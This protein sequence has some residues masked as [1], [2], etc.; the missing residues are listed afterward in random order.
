MTGLG[1]PPERTWDQRLVRVLGPETGV[2]P[3]PFPRGE[4][5]ENITFRRT[6]YAVVKWIKRASVILGPIITSG[7]L[8]D[9]KLLSYVTNALLLLCSNTP[10]ENKDIYQ[11]RKELFKMRGILYIAKGLLAYIYQY[12]YQYSKT[13]THQFKVGSPL[14][15]NS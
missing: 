3:P 11:L 7:F 2:N 5:T 10:S 9:R 1:V 15:S 8:I 6:S 14:S 13:D 4:Q 12:L